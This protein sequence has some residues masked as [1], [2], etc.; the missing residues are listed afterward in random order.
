[1]AVAQVP[2]GISYQAIALNGSGTP[3][4]TSNV[5]LRLSVLNTS[6]TGI[7][8]YTETQVKT[9]NA[10]GL[11]N[12]IIGQGTPVTGTLSGV[13]WN[14]G[15]KF[16]KVEM[17][18][19]GGTNYVL[20]GTTQLLSVPYAMA[21]GSL[22]TSATG[23]TLADQ[24]NESKFANFAFIDYTA[25]KVNVYN[26]RNGSWSS[27][28]FSADGSPAITENSGNF[29][30]IDYT[31]NKIYIFSA[32]TGSWSNQSF[33]ADSSPTLITSGNN[34]AFID[35]TANKVYAYN[36]TTG[37]WLSQ[38]FTAEGSPTVEGTNG[39]FTFIDYT[40][41]K[42]YIYNHITATWTNQSFTADGSPD[43]TEV[44]GIMVFI[45]YTAN[46]VYAFSPATGTWSSQ[47]F[48][49]E[50]SPTIISSPND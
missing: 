33:S 22:A 41:N 43:V 5:G 48:T 13:N 37:I 12:L 31:A 16:L 15:L 25:N 39:N 42:V 21:A 50:S 2:Q 23:N 3:V 18:V 28:I 44:N 34:V 38:S 19:Y 47:S 1:L 26:A 17:D 27:Q 11:F 49:A 46:K 36:S 9:T 35:Y 32:K 8:V 6:A 4:V 24:I 29:R 40:A 30:F 45:D 14:N 7:V 20:I 10:Q